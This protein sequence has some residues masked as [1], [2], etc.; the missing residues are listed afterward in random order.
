MQTSPTSRTTTDLSFLHTHSSQPWTSHL[1]TPHL[2]ASVLHALPSHIGSLS[3]SLLVPLLL[4]VVQC[5]PTLLRGAADSVR[6]IVGKCREVED[7]W[8]RWLA[9]RVEEL[10]VLSNASSFSTDSARITD[11]SK[12]VQER[13]ARR[14]AHRREASTVD[15]P[16]PA[17]RGDE[18]EED[19]ER[20]QAEDSLGSARLVHHLPRVYEF[21][22]LERLPAFLTRPHP[23]IASSSPSTAPRAL[24]SPPPIHFRSRCRFTFS[25]PVEQTDDVVAVDGDG[26]KRATQNL[27]SAPPHSHPSPIPPSP[28]TPHLPIAPLSSHASTTSASIPA[29]L[30]RRISLPA[31]SHLPPHATQSPSSSFSSSASA[32]ALAASRLGRVSS[33]PQ[34]SHARPQLG[35][36][37]STATAPKPK[38]VVML[39]LDEVEKLTD[40]KGRLREEKEE[41]KRERDEE[42]RHEQERRT[43]ER[44][45]QARE[46]SRVREEKEAKRLE[47]H[48]VR[49]EKARERE[50]K[51]KRE[52]EAGEE[53][54][55]EGPESGE[56]EAENRP[57]STE[58]RKETAGLSRRPS[59]PAAAEEV[60]KASAGQKSSA[61]GGP[62]ANETKKSRG[63]ANVKR[64]KRA[65][66]MGSSSGSGSSS[67]DDGQ[68]A[69]G[70]KPP[71]KKDRR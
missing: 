39:G 32:L 60:E 58:E 62:K 4:A 34:S 43:K 21:A 66:D 37:L 28:R 5:K 3:P 18:Q 12:R 2:T 53:M 70:T 1:L 44:E 9:G 55:R 20:R 29:A 11:A 48:R 40:V 63:T 6:E 50:E 25:A 46:R 15:K 30:I 35:R 57:M 47:W 51:R 33:L 23:F 24:V 69:V 68:A 8:V 36:P 42:K 7:D 52:A 45:E 17:A 27:A 61:D 16:Q 67:E 54:K 49:E 64:K 26:E 59:S 22:S 65:S 14:T 19:E 41:K 38:G 10:L 56:A 31:S 13:L 71:R